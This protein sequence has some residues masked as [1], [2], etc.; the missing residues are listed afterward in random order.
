VK[1]FHL[2][3]LHIRDHD[4]DQ[5]WRCLHAV[6]EKAQVERPDLVVV[7]GDI[8]DNQ[9]V[10]LG[11]DS[12]RLAVGWFSQIAA[13]APVICV[14]GTPSHDGKAPEILAH[15]NNPGIWVSAVPEQIVV[16][17]G[18]IWTMQDFWDTASPDISDCDL[19]V[20]LVP[21]PTKQFWDSRGGILET[22]QEISQ[23][24]SGIF[25][26]FGDI[27]SQFSCPHIL[28][29]HFSVRGAEISESQVMVGREIEIGKDQLSLANA[30]LVLLGHIHKRQSIEPNIFYSGSLYPLNYGEKEDKGYY[31]QTI[32]GTATLSQFIKTPH[33][34]LT[35]LIYDFTR[36]EEDTLHDLDIVLYSLA[37]EEVQGAALRVELRV[38]QDEAEQLDPEGIKKFYLDGDFSVYRASSVEVRIVRVPRENV[39]CETI[40]KAQKLREKILERARVSGENGVPES[41]LEKADSL[42]ALPAQE[43]VE[44]VSR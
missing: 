8:F 11:S 31:I 23:T 36:H 18:E 25:A 24:M 9:A 1:I 35:R 29:G 37:P 2:A 4:I 34:K 28:V 42:E 27:A 22:D 33:R 26:G 12:A 20:S 39:R 14:T 21:A 15:I 38:W 6:T 3:D 43:L 7:A 16:A 30:H 40:L 32:D 10:K 44:R 5:C 41:I 17:K 13:I 19:I